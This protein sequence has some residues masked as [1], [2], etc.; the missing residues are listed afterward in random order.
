MN[1]TKTSPAILQGLIEREG[2]K[3]GMMYR[4]VLAEYR[5]H[6]TMGHLCGYVKVPTSSPLYD[7]DE[8]DPSIEPL[9]VHGGITYAGDLGTPGEWWIGFDC[10]H[11]GDL[12]PYGPIQ[13][14]TY[15]D[16]EFVLHELRNLIDQ[17]Y[18]RELV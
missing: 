2:N 13:Y 11:A 6:E 12:V 8:D 7:C 17:L 3:G 16:V 15:R 9:H 14:G 18:D 10:A 1:E 4:G 5:R